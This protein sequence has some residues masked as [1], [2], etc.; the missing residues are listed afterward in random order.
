MPDKRGGMKL[1]RLTRPEYVALD[2]AGAAKSGGR[3]SSPGIPLVNFASEPGLAVL[4]ALRYVQ[5]TPAFSD[6]DFVL[7]WTTIDCDVERVPHALSREAK[8]AFVD[9]WAKQRR[10][11][12]IAVQSAVLPEADIILMNPLHADAADIAPLSTRPFRFS[13]CLH[14]PPMLERYTAG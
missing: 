1:W 7:G 3:Y 6:D 13:E 2:G 9:A 8:V 5:A 12:A 4:V 14:R 10:S 11:L